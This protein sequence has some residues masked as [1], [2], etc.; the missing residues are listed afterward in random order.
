MES[1]SLVPLYS[2]PN[3]MRPRLDTVFHPLLPYKTSY[4]PQ[5]A[6]TLLRIFGESWRRIR[7]SRTDRSMQC[8]CNSL[9]REPMSSWSLKSF[10]WPLHLLHWELLGTGLCVY[11]HLFHL[12]G[13]GQNAALLQRVLS[14]LAQQLLLKAPCLIPGEIHGPWHLYR[15]VWVGVQEADSGITDISREHHV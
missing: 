4:C 14:W 2:G 10:S 9:L 7:F 6:G 11:V 5:E 3:A 13:E 8:W 12:H 15:K 1:L